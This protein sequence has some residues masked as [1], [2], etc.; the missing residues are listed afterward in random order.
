MAK[1]RLYRTGSSERVRFFSPVGT[2]D[3]PEFGFDDDGELV[4][5]GQTDLFKSIQAFEAESDLAKIVERCRL[6]GTDLSAPVEAF[7]DS[8][9]L[10]KSL[11]EVQDQVN[12]VQEFTNSL[13]QE[14]LQVLSSKGFDQFIADK[15]AAIQQAQQAQPVKDG[16]HE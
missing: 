16:D 9:Q 13:S 4:V 2:H 3:V 12:R 14:D 15:L 10:P 8:T 6:L 11:L 7:G 1:S 5:T